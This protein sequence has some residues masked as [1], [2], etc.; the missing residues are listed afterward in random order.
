MT[1]DV[2]VL[3]DPGSVAEAAAEMFAAAAERAVEDRGRFTVALAGG[4]TP[5]TLYRRLAE[6]EFADRIP[7]DAGWYA[8]GDERCVAPDHPDSNFRAADDAL[9]AHVSIPPDRVLRMPGELEQPSRAAF[10]YEQRLRELFPGEPWPRFDLVLLGLGADGHTASLFPGTDALL[11]RERW[12]TAN[13]APALDA[14]RLTLT[15]PVLCAAREI[16]FVVTGRDKAQ[17]VAE[18]FC[19]A[20]HEPPHPAELVVPTDGARE[21]LVDAAAAA[22]LDD[23]GKWNGGA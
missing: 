19:G 22:L 18:A 5:Q 8:F 12:T 11:E 16:L 9:L 15:L 1:G 17:A 23:E 13:W 4:R 7:W 21:V 3:A 6:R 10:F 14:W 2:L 20:P